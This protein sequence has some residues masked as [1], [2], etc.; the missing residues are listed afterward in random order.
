MEKKD[1]SPPDSPPEQ[2]D[3]IIDMDESPHKL[4][5][6]SVKVSSD[7]SPDVSAC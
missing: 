4:P 7:S 5:N 6:S 3:E 2:T 1:L